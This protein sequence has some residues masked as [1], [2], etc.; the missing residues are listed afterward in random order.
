VVLPNSLL[1]KI[2]LTNISRPDEAHREI[3]ALRIRP[4]RTPAF[5]VETLQQAMAAAN[6]ILQDPAPLVAL[7]GVDALAIDI[8]LQFRVRH[9]ADR[10]PARNELI[11]LVCR[12][13]A[14]SGIDFAA[15]ASATAF[16]HAPGDSAAPQV[17]DLLLANPLL[18][19]LGTEMPEQL[20]A[21]ARRRLFQP[22]DRLL[23]EARAAGLIVIRSGA[24]QVLARE[25]ATT[26]LGPG[27]AIGRTG[28]GDQLEYR[29]LTPLEA[30]EFDAAALEGLLKNAPAFR[31]A[32]RRHL[33]DLASSRSL[34]ADAAKDVPPPVLA[35]F[36]HGFLHR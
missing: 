12:Q 30:L 17:R 10:I 16:V 13:C 24:V 4:A 14:A 27:A 2:G 15:P 20:A 3:L 35:R 31:D 1:A 19:G 7:K 23:P 8:D 32:F 21:S 5:I 29:A 25:L 33:S 34:D 18:A 26:R 11:D 28:T 36:V 6:V 9:P 22:G